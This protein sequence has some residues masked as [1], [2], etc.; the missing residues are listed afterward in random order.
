MSG[1]TLGLNITGSGQAKIEA[2]TSAVER[3]VAA[4]RTLPSA[5]AEIDKLNKAL[6]KAPTGPSGLKGGAADLKELVG[7]F[8]ALGAQLNTSFASLEETIKKGWAKAQKA[9]AEGE[10]S[11]KSSSKA[12]AGLTFSSFGTAGQEIQ[13]DAG[14]FAKMQT[15][16]LKIAEQQAAA[17]GKA[18]N[19]LQA[20]FFQ[21][22]AKEDEWL[23][24][25]KL[26][27]AKMAEAHRAAGER[28]ANA[29]QAR[30]DRIAAAQE[31]A[32]EK[33]RAAFFRQF[34]LQEEWLL[35]L[36]LQSAKMAE[37]YRVSSEKEAAAIETAAARLQ[38]EQ[39]KAML[40]FEGQVAKQMAAATQP[41]YKNAGPA[42]W[43][44]I[45]AEQEAATAKLEAEYQKTIVKLEGMV[46][47]QMQAATR[48]AYKNAG[49]AWWEAVIA[50]QEAAAAKLEAAYLKSIT[51]LESL[52]S[53]QMAAA[54]QPAYKNAGPAWWDQII[55]EQ[56]AATA[57][58]EAEYQKTIVKLEK[59]VAAE[60][61]AAT[62]PAYQPA[63][64]AWWDQVIAEQEAA[65]LRM[66][67]LE[68]KFAASSAAS[69][70]ATILAARSQLDQGIA[71]AQVKSQYGAGALAA[72]EQTTLGAAMAKVHGEAERGVPKI[73]GYNRALRDMHSGLRG[74][75]SGFGQMALTWGAI[76][77]LLAG[78]AIGQ[79][80]VQSIKIGA[81]VRQ[82]LEELRVL[83]D[84]SQSAV[85]G[86]EKQLISLGQTG[87]FG[88]REVAEAMKTLSLA[89]LDAQQVG[90]ALKPALDFAVTGGV[91]IKQSSEALVAIGT[92]YG[93]QAGEFGLVA[94]AVAKAAAVSMSSVSG[95]M[96]SFK[97]SSVVAQAYGVT[98]KDSAT[99]LAMLA[100]IGIRNS[101]AGTA[102][103]QMYSELSGATNST[104]VAMQRLGVSVVDQGGKMRPV[105]DIMLDLSKALDKYT[106]K[107]R[108]AAIQTLS[109]ERG[110]KSIVADLV[111][112]EK[113]G[114]TPIDPNVAAVAPKGIRAEME[115]IEAQAKRMGQS[116][117]SELE[118]I[119]QLI[120]ESAGFNAVAASELAST[121][122]NLM[123]GVVASLQTSLFEAFKALEPTLIVA[124]TQMREVF[125][126]EGFRDGIT[127][128][129]QLMGAFTSAIIENIGW[130]KYLAI[131]FAGFKALQV[132]QLGLSATAV[133]MGLL[134]KELVV[135]S[136]GIMAAGAASAA[137]TPAL[138]GMALAARGLSVALA[139]AG[140]LALALT[141]AAFAWQVYGQAKKDANAE[142][143]TDRQANTLESL[144][145]E[146]ERLTE[147]VGEMSKGTEARLAEVRALDA[148]AAAQR[149]LDYDKGRAPLVERLTDLRGLKAQFE[150]E[151]RT[152]QAQ[153]VDRQIAG[154]EQALGMHDQAFGAN[155]K[156]INSERIKVQALSNGLE[157]LRQSREKQGN[158]Q[159][160]NWQKPGAG[161]AESSTGLDLLKKQYARE[162]QESQ[163]AY[164][165]EMELL[166]I[167]YKGKLVSEAE[168][169]TRSE[170][171]ASDLYNRDIANL[172][173]YVSESARLIQKLQSDPKKAPKAASAIAEIEAERREK[174][175]QLV[176]LQRKNA[177]QQDARANTRDT[178]LKDGLAALTAE[179][180]LQE[181]K[182]VADQRTLGMTPGMIAAE[183]AMADVRSKGAK[184][185][186]DT[187][188]LYIQASQALS[189]LEDTPEPDLDTNADAY[190]AR[191][192]AI[193]KLQAQLLNLRKSL[194]AGYAT[195]EEQAGKSGATAQ[196]STEMGQATWKKWMAEGQNAITV[197]TASRNEFMNSW[198]NQGQSMWESFLK[199]GKVSWKSLGDLAIKTIAD[200]SYKQGVGQVFA[201]GGEG[202]FNRVAPLVQGNV[203]DESRRDLDSL[204]IASDELG[205]SMGKLGGSFW[206]LLQ[207]VGQG[208]A[209][210]FQQSGA[211]GSAGWLTK[212]FGGGGG[213]QAYVDNSGMDGSVDWSVPSAKGNV[214]GAQGLIHAFAKGGLPMNTVINEPHYFRFGGG[215]LGVA[216]E[217]GPEAIMPL[218]RGSDG[219]LGVRAQGGGE[220]G[221][222]NVTSKTTVVIENHSGGAKPEVQQ[223]RQPDGS[224][225]IRVVI[226]AAAKDISRGG[227][228]RKSVQNVQGRGNLPRY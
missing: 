1:P 176:F 201:K 196:G 74:V 103:R 31:A 79:S 58:L 135:T 128:L 211:G 198:I 179:V 112:I 56:E 17:M 130:L 78:A 221:S 164:R 177:D 46:A 149:R 69:R 5:A 98:L 93:Y 21:R 85:A 189:A 228:L 34:E 146:K 116:A 144:R 48:P 23:L 29:A 54:T 9:N 25:L 147:V 122:E 108:V 11:V 111:G 139:V 203:S 52:V 123:K 97:A 18:D 55:A 65:L 83:S 76:G 81:S 190:L 27:S 87:P 157:L 49:P 53:K 185:L 175:D 45:I 43:D 155:E 227:D 151:G 126:S 216:G 40:R 75:A 171:L 172:E 92:A 38:A 47:K 192:A 119:R 212:L 150:K 154:A 148:Q 163:T 14:W 215:N 173:R 183:Q 170:A 222:V 184:A 4:L 153:E 121:P 219:T 95:M 129:V 168:Y 20:A 114:K 26:N 207:Q 16:S 6:N 100:N 22:Y 132:F 152:G 137:A 70:N 73:E 106:G 200:I 209:A 202:L 199:T 30:A 143:A 134:S 68:A 181:Q 28:E 94:D 105:I 187:V 102:M 50:E 24:K 127:T 8:K 101:A 3:L 51:K 206:Q 186:K 88:P 159:G 214:F 213:N 19:L 13:V 162:E 210:M 158:T 133:V 42:W 96:E 195:V 193:A 191:Q 167:R 224:E 197:L 77:P 218:T 37:A 10:A 59:L 161:V 165:R 174:Q 120:E 2:T 36:K 91:S 205:Q 67:Q 217:A 12:K 63:G 178:K 86:L 115:A 15:G 104:R 66:Q 141:A 84:E 90:Q 32:D 208:F 60:M 180:S 160:L 7:E 182:Y 99:S 109:N 194:N 61:K 113:P 41:A 110:S 125:N 39:Q 166:D 62:K 225:L 80:F 145:K 136:T 223:Q 82:D 138:T 72:A 33:H 71:P 124:A 44:Q 131:G 204:K 89:G 220:G 35:K 57:K 226:G 142:A 107:A 117:T 140:P 188:D 156:A 118:R 64:P 169:A